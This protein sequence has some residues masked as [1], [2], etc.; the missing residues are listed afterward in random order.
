M[1]ATLGGSSSCSLGRNAGPLRLR[2][3]DDGKGMPPGGV[4]ESPEKVRLCDDARA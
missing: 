4:T 2:D 1:K 3:D